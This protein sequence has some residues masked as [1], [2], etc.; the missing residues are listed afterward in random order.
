MNVTCPSCSTVYRVDPAKVPER[1]VRARCRVCAAIFQVPPPGTAAA[2]PEVAAPARPTHAPPLPTPPTPEPPP[3][4]P[5]TVDPWGDRAS[6]R[7][8]PP[9]PVGARQTMTPPGVA[10][11]VPVPEPPADMITPERPQAPPPPAMPSR[12]T[13][14][15]GVTQ[16]PTRPSVAIPPVVPPAART[17]SPAM[18]RPSAAVPPPPAPPPAPAPKTPKRAVNPFMSQDPQ[19][20]AKRLARALISDLVVYYPDRRSEGLRKGNLPEVFSEEIKKS[21]E[22]YRDQVGK[23]IAE[24]TTYFND[25]LNEILAGGQKVF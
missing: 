15:R 12:T 4:A 24:S 11:T 25:A 17:S 5:A 20:K 3:P 10:S 19:A 13:A 6:E 9:V 23:E 8:I 16:V 14:P 22:E 1:G 2:A 7:G 18:G 21:F